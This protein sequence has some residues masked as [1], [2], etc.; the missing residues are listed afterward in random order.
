VPIKFF[1]KKNV[2]AIVIDNNHQE[3]N[4]SLIFFCSSVVL[5]SEYFPNPTIPSFN[6]AT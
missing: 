5:W 3:I 1:S 4:T 6:N 2:L